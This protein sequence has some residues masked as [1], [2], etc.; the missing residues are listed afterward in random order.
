MGSASVSRPKAVGRVSAARGRLTV[1][2]PLAAIVVLALGAYLYGIQR[3][4]PHAVEA[5]EPFFVAPAVRA[6]VTGDLN[7]KWFGHPGSTIIYPLAVIYH[8]AEIVA[9]HGP[10]VGPDRAVEADFIAHRRRFYVLARL[11]SVAWALLT[12]P[13][14]YLVGL[15]AFGRRAGILGALLFALL[16]IVVDHAQI[17]RTDTAGVFFAMLAMWCL[18]RLH[19]KPTVRRQLAAGAAI[20]LGIS[21]RYFLVLAVPL[22][23]TLGVAQMIRNRSEG[24]ALLAAAAPVACGLGAVVVAFAASTPYFFLDFHYAWSSLISENESHHLGADGLSPPGNLWWYLTSAIPRSMYALP[25]LAALAGAVLIAV[26]RRAEQLILLGFTVV[27]V[28]GV[29]LSHLHWQRWIIPVLPLLALFAAHALYAGADRVGRRLAFDRARVASLAGAVALAALPAYG[30]AAAVRQAGST[31]RLEARRWVIAHVPKGTMIAVEEYSAPLD[32]AGFTVTRPCSTSPNGRWGTTYAP[33]DGSSF[34]VAQ[35]CSLLVDGGV[36]DYYRRGYRYLI[37]SSRIDNRYRAEPRR[38]PHEVAFYRA[39]SR[40]ALLV[41]RFT[42]SA[43][44]AGPEIRIYRLNRP[45]A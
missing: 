41:A 37:T 43:T 21:T 45:I 27:F 7:P 19:E 14:V 26:G 8:G 40:Q 11:L 34:S 17:V 23:L 20:G 1:S 15:R 5:D 35:P 13:L 44:L 16:P 30:F 33:L 18:L 9:N 4:M 29:S 31:T 3:D 42:S 10:V 25:A 12:L 28:L 39:L 6:T 2:R 36:A 24:R 32:G 22:L 38:Y